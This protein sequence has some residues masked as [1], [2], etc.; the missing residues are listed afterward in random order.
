M[1]RSAIKATHP[2]ALSSR[3]FAHVFRARAFDAVIKAADLS[4]CAS[5]PVSMAPIG[6]VACRAV[7]CQQVSAEPV[8]FHCYIHKHTHDAAS[9]YRNHFALL[10][11]GPDFTLTIR[12][13]RLRRHVLVRVLRA[14]RQA[15]CKGCDKQSGTQSTH[16]LYS[17]GVSRI[18]LPSAPSVSTQSA[19]SGP[20]AT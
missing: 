10:K 20:V 7:D 15:D 13:A 18:S 5:I 12:K 19:P 4:G 9:S 17:A 16:S 11:R 2:Q 1:R 14:R 8:G 3:A 6:V